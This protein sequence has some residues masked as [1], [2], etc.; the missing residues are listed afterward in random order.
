[1]SS[2]KHREK[3]ALLM[4]LDDKSQSEP[5]LEPLPTSLGSTSPLS[6]QTE[7]KSREPPE[8]P[9]VE[10]GDIRRPSISVNEGEL[11]S[12]P[13]FGEHRRKSIGSVDYGDPGPGQV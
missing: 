10:Y 6:S 13:P 3:P 2:E 7:H 4:P 12:Q 8:Q 9:L 1:M 11:G 5:R